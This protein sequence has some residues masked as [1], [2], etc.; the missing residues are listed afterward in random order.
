ME[1]KDDDRIKIKVEAPWVNLDYELSCDTNIT[2]FTSVLFSMAV[3]LTYSPKIAAGAFANI[4]TGTYDE[5]YEEAQNHYTEERINGL[6]DG[7]GENDDADVDS[8]NES[9]DEPE[10]RL[11]CN[12]IMT[13]DGTIL[14]SKHTHDYV[15]Y[16]DMNGEMYF[17]DGGLDYQR[18]SVNK[19]PCRDI[20]IYS[21]APFSTIRK[22]LKRGTFDKDGNRIWKPLCELSD[23]HLNNILAYYSKPNW[24]TDYVK[25]EIEYRKENNIKIEDD[26]WWKERHN[27]ENYEED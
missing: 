27:G 22:Y 17:V 4:G 26:E 21:N 12:R 5:Y 16:V 13:P 6:L 1:H 3:A 2:S 7:L 11:I 9:P 24:F 14:E 19:V 18:R 15:S 8:N 10:V 20:S 23:S 25:Q